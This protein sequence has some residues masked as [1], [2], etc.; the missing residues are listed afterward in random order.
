MSICKNY[1]EFAETDENL[2]FCTANAN[3]TSGACYVKNIYDYIYESFYVFNILFKGDEGGPLVMERQD[4][5]TNLT[6]IGIASFQ[7]NVCP[8]WPEFPSRH[9]KVAPY[10][11]SWIVWFFR[12]VA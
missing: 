1:T 3:E 7:P 12:K 10:I 4:D 2:S 5:V 6:L 9:I 8:P 11:Q